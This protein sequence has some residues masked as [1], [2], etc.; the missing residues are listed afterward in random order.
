[1]LALFALNTYRQT[2]V[3]FVVVPIGQRQTNGAHQRFGKCVAIRFVACVVAA[4]GIGPD[5]IATCS[6]IK[7]RRTHWA[8]VVGKVCKQKRISFKQLV[9]LFGFVGKL[10][11]KRRQSKRNELIKCILTIITAAHSVALN[12][13]HRSLLRVPSSKRRINFFLKWRWKTWNRDLTCW[14]RSRH[15]FWTWCPEHCW[16]CRVSVGRKKQ[17]HRKSFQCLYRLDPVRMIV[18]RKNNNNR[19]KM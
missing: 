16:E 5:W 15:R 19:F 13:Y 9:I 14:T 8:N 17:R 18:K 7:N 3:V 6:K 4:T 2:I 10:W 1:M 12:I 11:F